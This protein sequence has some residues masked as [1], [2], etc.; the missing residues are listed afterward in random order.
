MPDVLC[1]TG[2]CYEQIFCS[3]AG[4]LRTGSMMD[5]ATPEQV[6]LAQRYGTAPSPPLSGEKVGIARNV[7]QDIWPVNGL[8]HPPAGDTCGWYIWAGEELSSA[9]DF[10]VPLHAEHLSEWCPVALRFMALPPGWRFLVAPGYEDVWYDPSIL[11][12]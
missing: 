3:N 6:A 11:I 12:V 7:R 4:T 8:R 1:T 5:A 9:V 10:F 2:C